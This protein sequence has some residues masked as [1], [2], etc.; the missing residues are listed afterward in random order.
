VYRRQVFGS[1]RWLRT[2]LLYSATS[3]VAGAAAGLSLGLVSSG[4]PY[5]VRL[6]AAG[7]FSLLA[8]VIGLA[9]ASGRFVR[10]LQCDAETP[11]Q[12]VGQGWP[13]WAVRNGAALGFGGASRITFWAWYALPLGCLLLGQPFVTAFL[14]ALYGFTRASAL[15]P[16]HFVIS[17]R[18]FDAL[19]TTLLLRI[20]MARQLSGTWLVAIGLVTAM[21]VM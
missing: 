4:L 5:Q 8:I 14:Y 10:P 17:S 7:L 9:E 15:W 16:L 12:W 13:R 18:A 2:A 1:S 3:T 20:G 6:G 11:R 19:Q 21:R